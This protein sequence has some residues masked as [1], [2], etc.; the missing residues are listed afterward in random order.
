MKRINE[1][2]IYELNYRKKR[3]KEI[4]KVEKSNYTATK[5]QKYTYKCDEIN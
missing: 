1:L 2:N 4:F 3:N 5:T